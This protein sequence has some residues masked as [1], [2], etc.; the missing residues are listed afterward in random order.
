MG[1]NQSFNVGRVSSLESTTQSNTTA[2]TNK[3]DKTSQA[4]QTLPYLDISGVNNALTMTATVDKTPWFGI[5]TDAYNYDFAMGRF[6]TNAHD[7]ELRAYMDKMIVRTGRKAGNTNSDFQIVTNDSNTAGVSSNIILSPNTT[8]AGVTKINSVLQITPPNTS[9]FYFYFDASSNA[10]LN[11][12]DVAGTKLGCKLKFLT[13]GS[14]IQARKADDSAFIPFNASSFIV[15]SMEDTKEEVEEYGETVLDKIKKTKV[16]K[17]K[18][19]G[20][21]TDR[22]DIGLIFEES[23]PELQQGEGVSLYN[24][25]AMLW[26]AVQELQ[27]QI[28]GLKAK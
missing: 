6:H 9:N 24:M 28:E 26:K 16:R 15:G 12:S 19:K 13:D 14:S 5:M 25:T 2:L 4:K 3:V 20:H 10:G 21:D 18:L 17:Y 7:I 1:L 23:P 8:T 27:E 11:W 22:K